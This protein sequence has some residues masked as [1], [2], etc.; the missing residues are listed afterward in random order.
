VEASFEI[1]RLNN[2]S[3]A[4]EKALCPNMEVWPTAVNMG[5]ENHL[6]DKSLDGRILLKLI[7]EK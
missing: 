3:L 5:S 1:G 6:R 2:L 7:M 4:A